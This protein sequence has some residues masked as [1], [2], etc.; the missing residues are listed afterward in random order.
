MSRKQHNVRERQASR[1]LKYCVCTGRED[2]AHE[3]VM[4]QGTREFLHEE[5]HVGE[6]EEVCNNMYQMYSTA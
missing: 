1:G 5:F 3:K 4:D 2:E 6:S